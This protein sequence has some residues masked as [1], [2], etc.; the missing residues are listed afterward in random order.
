MH[1]NINIQPGILRKQNGFNPPQSILVQDFD[2]DLAVM[3]NRGYNSIIN[4]PQEI[5]PIQIDSCGGNVLALFSILDLIKPPHKKPICCYT[6]SISA[7]CGIVLLSAG[8]PGFRYASP[9]AL[10]IAHEISSSVEGKKSD[11]LNE[12]EHMDQMND[13]LMD[14]LAH[15]SNKPRNFY[16]KLI[17]SNNNADCI[18]TAQKAKEYGLI[19]HIGI[20]ELTMEI[21]AKYT[22]TCKK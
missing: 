9:N 22:L 3:F 6:S 20:P 4:S 18:I 11:I 12:M 10:L 19:D 14:I 17:K 1:I 8:T 2:E 7:S 15:N 13:K 16:R 5:C 21:S